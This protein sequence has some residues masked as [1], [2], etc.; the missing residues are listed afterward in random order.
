M[1]EDDDGIANP[2]PINSSQRAS[3]NELHGGSETGV[4]ITCCRLT[5]FC[6]K[7]REREIDFC[8]L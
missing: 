5:K 7:K 6:K 1:T 8:V 3:M 4:R 2:T